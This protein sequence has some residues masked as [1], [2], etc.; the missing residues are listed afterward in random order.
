[1][2]QATSGDS[3]VLLPGHFVM[4]LPV[5]VKGGV[6]VTSQAGPLQTVVE[7]TFFASGQ[8]LFVLSG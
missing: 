8:E 1:M 4:H 5:T 2:A 6:T 3:L 7:H